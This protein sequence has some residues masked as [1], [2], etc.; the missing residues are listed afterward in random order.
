M[1]KGYKFVEHPDF[2]GIDEMESRYDDY[3]VFMT[4]AQFTETHGLLGGIPVIIA[5]T[6]YAGGDEGIYRQYF[7]D[8]KY[9]PCLG[10]SFLWDDELI[11]L[12]YKGGG[13][14]NG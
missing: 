4:N 14:N 6:P 11:R 2:V 9:M 5:D 10:K 8:D 13:L 7:E 3:W 12:I 1:E